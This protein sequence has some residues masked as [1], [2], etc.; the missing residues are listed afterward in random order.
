[1]YGKRPPPEPD[2]IITARLF[3]AAGRHV[4]RGWRDPTDDQIAT[5]AAELREIAG[6]R[7]DLLSEVPGLM[8]GTP[9]DD[10][11]L[12]HHQIAARYLIAAGAD[13]EA[14]CARKHRRH[15]S[16]WLLL[17]AVLDLLPVLFVQPEHHQL[18]VGSFPAGL[19][20]AADKEPLTVAQAFR[21]AGQLVHDDDGGAFE[22]RR[23]VADFAAVADT[24][25]GDGLSAQGQPP[26]VRRPRR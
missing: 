7:T 18:R 9:D 26:P 12:R 15:R 14:S 11:Y 10:S 22:R 4:P 1:V 25:D 8:M 23:F 16:S 19:V 3:G 13:E 17:A 21:V 6:G 20:L 5:A 24:G 2:G